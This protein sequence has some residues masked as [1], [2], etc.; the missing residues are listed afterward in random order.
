MVI[1]KHDHNSYKSFQLGK[2]GENIAVDHLLKMNYLILDRNFRIPGG[3]ID[4]V[5][6]DNKMLVFIEVKNYS[7]RNFFKPEYS[8]SERKKYRIRRTAEEYLYRKDIIN[9]DCR[10]D[11]ILIYRN[12][13]GK[14][15]IDH[16]KDVFL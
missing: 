13:M 8:I 5:A 11:V 2:D 14:K 1:N 12:I 15:E 10:F 7:Y 3:E 4:I 6:R 9:N 16:I